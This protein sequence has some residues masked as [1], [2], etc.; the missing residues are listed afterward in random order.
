[1]FGAFRC[2]KDGLNN[3]EY[4]DLSGNSSVDA[5]NYTVLVSERFLQST[6]VPENAKGDTETRNARPVT[7]AGIER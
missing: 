1:M 3:L 2:S 5:R 4:V 7:S 6:R